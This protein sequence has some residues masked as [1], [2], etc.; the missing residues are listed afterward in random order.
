M[1]NI[2]FLF[3]FLLIISIHD[4][5]ASNAIIDGQNPS[6]TVKDQTN[7]NNI[8]CMIAEGDSTQLKN[9]GL[10]K[11]QITGYFESN[12]T[13][14]FIRLENT[15]DNGK[16]KFGINANLVVPLGDISDSYQ[17]G[18]GAGLNV[19][20]PTKKP[21]CKIFTGLFFVYFPGKTTTEINSGPGWYEEV[22]YT[23]HATAIVSLSVGPQLGKSEG[24]YF[25]PAMSF[26]TYQSY[27]RVGF[28]V[29]GGFLFPS[30]KASQKFNIG[31]SLGLPNIIGKGEYEDTYM[32]LRVF[33]GMLF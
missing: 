24:I 30:K 16:A 18:Y 7:G 2:P 19:L 6:K 14:K 20:F 4:L 32:Y 26:I 8:V 11:S 3:A 17:L 13:Q 31:A 29:G 27:V 1:K 15:T 28:D 21:S 9:N 10:Q 12:R 25:L 23:T 22:T 33:V 5:I